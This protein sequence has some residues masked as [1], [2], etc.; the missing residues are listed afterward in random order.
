MIREGL[1]QDF[2]PKVV[3]PFEVCQDQ[4]R[5]FYHATV[6]A[7]LQSPLRRI[8]RSTCMVKKASLYNC[9]YFTFTRNGIWR[10]I[11]AILFHQDH[12]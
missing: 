10:F 12:C 6:V 11:D 8:D 5:R 7:V 3:V 1:W 9:N 4:V 2:P